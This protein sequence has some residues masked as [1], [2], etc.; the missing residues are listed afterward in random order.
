MR[1]YDRFTR[2]WRYVL[3]DLTE[4]QDAKL[5]ARIEELTAQQDELTAR[6]DGHSTVEEWEKLEV[7]LQRARMV[8]L[9]NRGWTLDEIVKELRRPKQTLSKQ[10]VSRVLNRFRESGLDSLSR[11]PGR[12]PQPEVSD[13]IVD[14]LRLLQENADLR[15]PAEYLRAFNAW[16]DAPVSLPT[17]RRY[18]RKAGIRFRRPKKTKSSL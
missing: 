17:L 1:Y 2:R 13:E 6:Q 16:A 9:A 18:L 5:Q 3:I 15:T 10:T 14:Y 7:V 12:P 11:K 8:D 4:D